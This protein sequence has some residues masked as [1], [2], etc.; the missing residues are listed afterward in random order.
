MAISPNWITGVITVPRADMTL[1]QSVPTEIR[2]LNLNSFHKE[3]R[4]LED[5]VDGRPWPRT[6]DHNTTVELGGVTYA[7]VL[8]ILDPYTVTFEDGQYAV[9]LT[10]A[11]SNVADKVNVNQVSVRSA[12]SAGLVDLEILIASAYQGHVVVSPSKG[13]DGTDEPIGTY[14]VPS[15]NMADAIAIAVKQGVRK[16]TLLDSMTIQEDLSLGY[17][18]EGI[19]PFIVATLDT[20]ANVVG[21]AFT[22]I[23][24]AG[25]LDGLS[26]IQTASLALTEGVSGFVFQTALTNE[27][28]VV[29]DTLILQ[30]FS[31]REGGLYPLVRVKAGALVVRDF[32]GS[33]GLADVTA[34]SHSIGIYGGRAVIEASCVGGTIHLRGEPFE[35]IDNSGPLCTVVDE[36]EGN[37]LRTIHTR[38][39]LEQGNAWT[40]TPAQSSDASG[41]I[42]INNTGDGATTSTGTRQ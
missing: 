25:Y 18:I 16:F 12:N 14:A 6:H 34:G 2:Q 35:I 8:E 40:D 17:T 32:R 26:S 27:T 7:R 20:V 4:A 28:E 11:N 19:S 13:Q 9:N 30:C 37:K 23:T 42:V 5:S 29:N 24:L 41:G 36:T 10:G 22:L 1:I 15:S 3:L 21:C 33:I 38:L 31:Q 39:G